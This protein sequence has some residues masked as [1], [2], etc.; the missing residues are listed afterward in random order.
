MKFPLI[1]SELFALQKIST[2]SLIDFPF[3]KK[4][5]GE[6]FSWHEA[7]GEKR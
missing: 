3:E 2:G 1:F 6:C 5:T 7:R 4:L